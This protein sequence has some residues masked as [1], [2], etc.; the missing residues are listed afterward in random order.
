VIQNSGPA[1]YIADSNQRSPSSLQGGLFF[2]WPLCRL[3]HFPQL[4]SATASLLPRFTCVPPASTPSTQCRFILVPASGCACWQQCAQAV[5]RNADQDD[6][7]CTAFMAV[8]KL[9]RAHR[10]GLDAVFCLCARAA[11]ASCSL[12]TWFL[13]GRVNPPTWYVG[14]SDHP[15]S[16]VLVLA[17]YCFLLVTAYCCSASGYFLKSDVPKKKIWQYICA[18]PEWQPC[19]IFQRVKKTIISHVF[20][21]TSACKTYAG[22]HI[23][24]STSGNITRNVK[25]RSGCRFLH[26]GR[27][28]RQ[29]GLGS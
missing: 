20:T 23:L 16:R 10:S 5:R 15:F 28:R 17:A 9:V 13:L 3:L 21:F 19:S 4:S 14:A 18:A 12:R 25:C 24:Y 2:T 11:G 8:K 6:V 29:D 7:S 22:N 26:R 1:D 27:G